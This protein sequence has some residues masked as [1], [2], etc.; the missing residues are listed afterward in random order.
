MPLHMLSENDITSFAYL[1]WQFLS[2]LNG[3]IVNG[4]FSQFVIQKILRACLEYFM[5]MYISITKQQQK[6]YVQD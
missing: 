5:I 6:T 4:G 2:I 1:H 3:G